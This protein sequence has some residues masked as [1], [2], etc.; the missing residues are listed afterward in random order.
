MVYIIIILLAVVAGEVGILVWR[1]RRN[2]G[3]DPPAALSEKGVTE[4]PEADGAEFEKR[5]R[6]GIDA[7][8]GYDLKTARA[9]VRRGEDER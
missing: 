9:A 7:M 8:M 6:E 5:W 1:T 4:T 3:S 2:G